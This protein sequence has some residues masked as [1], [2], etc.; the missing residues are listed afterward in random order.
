LKY[1]K[2]FTA[3]RHN[4]Y[5]IRKFSVGLASILVGSIFFYGQNAQAAE[6]QQSDVSTAQSNEGNAQATS[7]TA[8]N[9]NSVNAQAVSADNSVAASSS[10]GNVQQPTAQATSSTSQPQAVQAPVQSTDQAQQNVAQ[11]SQQVVKPVLKQAQI[12]TKEIN[13]NTKEV[14]VFKYVEENSKHLTENERQFFLRSVAR[15]T[16]LAD[17]NWQNLYNKNYSANGGNADTRNIQESKVQNVKIITDA[18]QKLVADRDKDEFYTDLRPDNKAART[19]S[20]T[21]NNNIEKDQDGKQS[22]KLGLKKT[23]IPITYPQGGKWYSWN[24]RFEHWG[25]R[26]NDS[27]NNKI[28]EVRLKYGW[29]GKQ[30]DE[31]VTRDKDGFYWFKQDEKHGFKGHLGGAVDFV[32]KFKK[33]AVIDKTKDAIWGYILSDAEHKNPM[34]VVNYGFKKFNLGQQNFEK[35]FNDSTLNALKQN[36]TNK[37]SDATRGFSE[38]DT[39]KNYYLG[40]VNKATATVT[41]SEQYAEATAK[42]TNIDQRV[43][44]ALEEVRPTTPTRRTVNANTKDVDVLKYVEEYSKY[45]SDEERKFF[46]RQ[47]TR[48]SGFLAQ[49]WNHIYRKDYNGISTNVNTR[50][51]G[52]GNVAQ[53]NKLLT[54]LYELI[55]NRNNDQ[56]YKELTNDTASNNLP[57]SYT[58][59]NNITKSNGQ[60]TVKVTV[61]KQTLQFSQYQ[62]GDWWDWKQRFAQWGLRA[63]EA[64]NRK[65]DKVV[66]KYRWSGEDKEDILVRDS[67][68]FYWF[69]EDEK[70][71]DGKAKV[72]GSVDF[73]L[74]FKKDAV[75]DKDNDKLWG[76]VISDSK[77]LETRAGAN[78]GF[79]KVDF[80]SVVSTFNGQTVSTLK[81][82]LLSNIETLKPVI[83]ANELDANA[84]K[85]KVE[86]VNTNNLSEGQFEQVKSQLEALTKEVAQ[87]ALKNNLVAVPGS[88]EHLSHYAQ[89]TNDGYFYGFQSLNTDPVNS[90]NADGS[91]TLKP[92]G[93]LFYNLKAENELAPGKQVNLTILATQVAENAKFEYAVQGENDQYIVP[94]SQIPKTTD[95]QYK[96][97]NFT[98][99]QGAK[100][101]ALRLDNRQGTTNTHVNVFTLVPESNKKNK[102]ENLLVIPDNL[103]HIGKYAEYT[104]DGQFLSFQSLNTT[105]INSFNADGSLTLKPKGYLFYNLKAQGALAPGKQFN[106]L[107]MTSQV[108]PNTKLEYG[109]HDQNNRLNNTVTAITKTNEGSYR[110]DNVT[111]PENVKDIALR[112]DNR[113]GTSDTII[114]GVF[115]LPKK[116]TEV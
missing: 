36:V 91:V 9:N 66:A 10:N 30:Y 53:I 56:L 74:T 14:D 94:I 71:P 80:A 15:E 86:A 104:Q 78:V 63:N 81:Q 60:Q 65:I 108:D 79:G 101:F 44:S 73:Y 29:N 16:P 54:S 8:Q 31:V 4:K 1:N 97:Q 12:E 19:N 27:I 32:V 69:K 51:I 72:G 28:K 33:N 99:P 7:S 83:T 84:L 105:P 85:T 38:Q 3:R 52:A 107:V 110:I 35:K 61:G 75:I 17:R 58:L 111:V 95:G 6:G 103:Q 96:L 50:T 116:T 115:V 5:S 45:L 68:G 77:E 98:I 47:V 102:A 22:I 48:H 41:T 11:Q 39:Q 23:I 46:L 76:Y 90:L 21:L 82:E 57:N 114:Q 20:F 34:A 24:H 89:S 18:L 62:N 93:Y 67:K 49:D 100:K 40:L 112:L 59:D 87:A 88:K 92:K 13:A 26:T 106:I 37:I 55:E 42:L 70:F 64:L 2:E 109:F 25:L 43:T 113:T